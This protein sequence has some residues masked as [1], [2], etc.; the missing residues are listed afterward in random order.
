MQSLQRN[1]FFSLFCTFLLSLCCVGFG[2]PSDLPFLSYA[3][4]TI[5]YALFWRKCMESALSSRQIFFS[6]WLLFAFSSLLQTRWLLS[7]PYSYIIF[8]WFF[9]SCLLSFPYAYLV[10]F[11]LRSSPSFAS[12]LP[13]SALFACLDTIETHLFFCGIS[14]RSPGAFLMGNPFSCQLI[15]LLGGIGLT[16]L[17]AFL[18][19]ALLLISKQQKPLAWGFLLLCMPIAFGGF[20]P[21]LLPTTASSPP[22][23]VALFHFNK[24]ALVDMT[25]RASIKE[26]KETWKDIF[27]H[28]SLLEREQ[29]DL[30]LLPEGVVPY[31]SQTALFRR[32]ELPEEIGRG[33]F[34]HDSFIS[35]GEIA[36]SLSLLWKSPLLLGMERKSTWKEQGYFN[37]CFLYSPDKPPAFYDKQV[38]VP[39]GEY[40]PMEQFFKPILA[41]YGVGGSFR[42]GKG[43]I[44]LPTVK[45]ALFPL[46]CYEETL[47]NYVLPAV[48]LKADLLIALSNDH[49][50]PSSLFAREH[51][52][53]GK[54]RAM[55][56]GLS[57]LRC[58]NM[59]RSGLILADGTEF[60][61]TGKE[62]KEKLLIFSFVPIK[63]TTPYSFLRERVSILFLFACAL[64]LSLATRTKTKN[65]SY[66]W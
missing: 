36:Q 61:S 30:V 43:P 16:F 4:A 40:V 63:R 25:V 37:S 34:H 21:T 19:G 46:I 29:V 44:L 2:R 28:A 65:S 6:L 56:A 45:A 55:E 51:Q 9:L 38:L 32:E 22:L 48:P 62:Q 5:G 53:L 47:S 66:R 14:F 64:I 39:G 31:S 3:G 54:M 52:L 27:S 13:L 24:K 7:H 58:S 18:N 20:L 35:S 49:W 11:F 60:I 57:I 12:L 8:I 41:R 17:V 10:H 33:L 1:H 26:Y 23:K 42:P 15:T 50:F 59:G